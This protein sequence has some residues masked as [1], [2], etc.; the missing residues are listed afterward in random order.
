METPRKRDIVIIGSG[1]SGGAAMWN[2]A[3]NNYD[4]LC[5]EQGDWVDPNTY[6][7]NSKDWQFLQKTKW[8]VSPNI[9]KL[10]VDYQINE[11]NSEISVLMYNA[12][13][14]ST[15]HWTAHAPR[16]HPSDFRVKTLDGVADDWPIT[17]FDLEKYYDLN[18]I[19]MGC[20]GINGD[21]ANPQRS[22]R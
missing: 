3:K 10:H 12:V 21:P 17:Y 6:A 22:P 7:T 16:F 20:S 9:R 15:I 11:E 8:S 4:V 19:M 2:L 5:L 13:G 14:G 18:D 1:A